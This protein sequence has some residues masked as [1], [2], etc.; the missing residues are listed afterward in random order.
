MF[1]MPEFDKEQEKNL[2]KYYKNQEEDS[3]RMYEEKGRINKQKHRLNILKEVTKNYIRKEGWLLDVGC[4]DG[5]AS[6]Y[7]LNSNVQGR[8][9]GIDLSEKKLK[10]V[11]YRLSGSKT[12]VGDSGYLP[13]A[14]RS[15]NYVLCL[16]TLEHLIE[17]FITLKEINRVLK[18]EGLA[19]ISIPIDSVLQKI[20]IQL[21]RKIW[22]KNSS[23]FQEHIQIF[24]L[25]YIDA[26]LKADNFKVLA[27]HF[28]GF[29]FPLS[30]LI[31]ENLPY[32]IFA[33]IDNFLCKIPFS[34]VGIGTKFGLYFGREYLIIVVQKS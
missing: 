21:A 8:Y 19:V 23:E 6:S 9:V 27:K 14:D 24:T 18:P 5:Y 2:Q 25:K 26:L 1:P 30:N 32:K 29:N 11:L 34:C 15:F 7:I 3:S 28:C 4:G 31:L 16:E 10:K 12:V 13:F 17:P 22:Q 33:S 20:L